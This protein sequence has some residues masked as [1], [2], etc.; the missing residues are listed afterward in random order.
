MKRFLVSALCLVT[1]TW[2]CQKEEEKVTP[3]VQ[4]AS[5]LTAEEQ[6]AADRMGAAIPLEDF[7]RMTEEF[8][9]SVGSED[10]RAVAYGKTVLEQVLSQKGCVGI[11]F[12]FAKDKDGKTTLVFI[13]V[14]KNG[15]DITTPVNAKTTDDAAQTGGGGPICPRRC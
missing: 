11:R 1:V 5:K 4:K 8:K 9:K 12:Y 7:K 10:T 2:A 13:G 6:Q 3:E 15:N 14:D